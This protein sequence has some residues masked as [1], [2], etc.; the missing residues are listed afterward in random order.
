MQL[1]GDKT[2]EA[3]LLGPANDRPI[4]PL[5][6]EEEAILLWDKQE[7]QEATT[8]CPEYLEAAEP[9]GLTKWADTPSTPAPSSAVPS[10]HRDQSRNTRRV[11]CRD[12]LRYPSTP[13]PNNSQ[14][15][16]R[17]Y[18]EVKLVVGVLFP[19]P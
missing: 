16:V 12:G 3:S 1:D 8:S 13:D 7:A 11:P 2:M 9:K 14:A 17:A 18:L 4:M 5:T 10:S 15:W 19:P 6:T